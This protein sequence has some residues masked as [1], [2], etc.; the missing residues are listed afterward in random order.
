VHAAV[1]IM[2][3]AAVLG[4][5]VAPAHAEPLAVD[6]GLWEVRTDLGS[7]LAVLMPQLPLDQRGKL[8]PAQRASLEKML[9]AAGARTVRDLCVTRAML[10]KGLAAALQPQHRQ[11]CTATPVST[12]AH[13]AEY[14]IACTGEPA[15]TGTAQLQA[16]DAHTVTATLDGTVA[17]K[18]GQ[19]QPVHMTV[20]SRWLGAGCGTVKPQ[21]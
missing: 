16:P 4:R 1:R 7:A 3:T 10:D 19:S 2:A 12:G 14:Q 5:L 15:G 18:D 21:G 6:P 20:Q 13:A 9:A 11:H 8:S 17:L